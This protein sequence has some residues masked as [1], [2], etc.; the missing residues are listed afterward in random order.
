[1]V[2]SLLIFNLPE[3]KFFIILSDDINFYLCSCIPQGGI[4]VTQ[5]CNMLHAIRLALT[6]QCRMQFLS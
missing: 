1:M 4:P 2:I 5:H 3:H 6:K